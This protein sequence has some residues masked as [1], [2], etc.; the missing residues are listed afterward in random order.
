MDNQHSSAPGSA[1]ITAPSAGDIYVAAARTSHLAH[2]ADCRERAEATE[3]R[4]AEYGESMA[5]RDRRQLDLGRR[6]M[7][8]RG[9]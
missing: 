3:A 5:R 4:I 7:R 2:C 9:W 8:V 6:A 1:L